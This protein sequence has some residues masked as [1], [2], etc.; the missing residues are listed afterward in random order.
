MELTLYSEIN[1]AYV[2]KG[3]RY[4]D[5][6]SALLK[7]EEVYDLL[8]KNADSFDRVNIFNTLSELMNCDYDSIYL[9][10]VKNNFENFEL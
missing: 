1:C 5:V 7:G 4:I 8:G 9:L 6:L 3:V 10:W 2:N